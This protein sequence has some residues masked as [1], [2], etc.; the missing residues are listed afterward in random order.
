MRAL[1]R[2]Y[3]QAEFRRARWNWSKPTAPARSSATTPKPDAL[4]EVFTE[5]DAQPQS[6]AI[7]SVK[8][9]IGHTKCAAGIGGMIKT[10]LALHHKVLPPTLVDQPNP[11]IKFEESP[12]YL[13]SDARPWVHGADHPR[14]AGVSAFG[15]GG[16]NY[17]I[18]MEEYTGSDPRP[19]AAGSHANWPAELF[20]WRRATRELLTQDVES[21]H[22]SPRRRAFAR[23]GPLGDVAEPHE[24]HGCGAS[25]PWRSWRLN[26][27]DLKQ[28]LVDRLEMC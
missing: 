12:L 17:H 16:T 8:S 7:G 18:V 25:P 3:S 1:R 5:S 10:A 9:M 26:A 14:Y 15:F 28:K 22:K 20:V 13:N 2:A 11:R 24:P 27:E 4:I 23:I 21:V 6:C 19:H